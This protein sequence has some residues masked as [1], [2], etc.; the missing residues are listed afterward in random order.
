[1]ATSYAQRHAIRERILLYGGPGTGKSRSVASIVLHCSDVHHYIIDNEID[2]YA[3]MFAEDPF[4]APLLERDNYTIYPVDS[5]DWLEQ[6]HA[7]QEAGDKA[8]A[9]DWLHFDMVTDTWEA[10]QRW[11]TQELFNADLSE[12][13][14]ASRREIEK[15]KERGGRGSK[16]LEAFDGWTDWSVINPQYKLLY[17]VFMGTK[18]HV[19]LV[20]EE[21]KVRSDGDDKSMK[22]TFGEVGWKPKGQKKL[23]HI[24]HTVIRLTKNQRDEW[25]MTGVKDRGRGLADE[26]K[27]TDFAKSY[28]LGIAGWKLK[29]MK[30]DA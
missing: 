7:T 29:P 4:L 2:N 18:A 20:A 26:V 28:L 14:L 3:R 16:S 30:S 9:G 13:F 25:M 8:Q 24:P 11:F 19:S 23:G 22:A 15:Q 1:M 5:Q 21:D 12:Y 27:F 10:V 17:R 6:L